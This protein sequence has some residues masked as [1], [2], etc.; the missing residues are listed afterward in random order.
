MP[1]HA[2]HICPTTS[3]PVVVSP[4]CRPGLRRLRSVP[5]SLPFVRDLRAKASLAVEH[6]RDL[7]AKASLAVEHVRDLR[8]KAR[9]KVEG[10]DAIMGPSLGEAQLTQR[11]IHI[12][13]VDDGRREAGGEGGD[14]EDIFEADSHRVTCAGVA[15]GEGR[16]GGGAFLQ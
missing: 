7:R 10:V 15:G 12:A 2:P 16:T 5:K 8:A 6:V 4:S 1:P 11:W 9:G 3:T 14:C 13:M